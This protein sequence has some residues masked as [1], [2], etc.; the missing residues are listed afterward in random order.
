MKVLSLFDG[1][2]CG[3][4]ALK[5]ANI[6]VTQYYASEIDKYAIQISKKNHPE[7]CQLGDVVNVRKMAECGILGK[8]DLLIGG[9]PCQGFSFAGKQLAFD[10]PRSVLFFEFV[11]TLKALQ[12]TN[13]DIKFLL[14]NVRMKKEYL[15]VISEQLGVRPV[16]INS[17]LVSA[18]NRQRYYWANWEISQPL[19]R[20]VMLKDIIE[21][22]VSETFNLSNK[23]VHG[24]KNGSP[25]FQG[26][27]NPHTAETKK[28]Y[29][30]TAR[31][32]KMGKTDPYIE[33]QGGAIRGRYNEDGKVEQQLELNHQEKANAITTVSKDSLLIKNPQNYLPEN[34]TTMFVDLYNKKCIEGKK[35][36]TLRTNSSNGNMWVGEN[37]DS[38]CIQIGE[39]DIKAHEERKRVYSPEGKCPTLLTPS[40]GYSEKKISTDNITWRKLT[41]IECERLQTLPDNYT[42]GVSNTQRYRMLGNGWTVSVIE[43]IFREMGK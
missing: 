39:A 20:G 31:Y 2:S 15:D 36:T 41:P 14:E 29:C 8:I 3:L 32:H 1:M 13:P 28:S 27:F 6:P 24:L 9:S 11:K 7:I 33:M 34:I 25:A 16:F 4:Q 38:L 18:Q 30:L 35:S 23:L 43:N 37:K 42:E 5:Q 12:K 22:D 17:A 40:G 19:D 10:D 26:R 21:D